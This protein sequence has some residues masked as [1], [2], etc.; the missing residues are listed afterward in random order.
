MSVS[1]SVMWTY[2]LSFA[3]RK[4]STGGRGDEKHDKAGICCTLE[5]VKSSLSFLAL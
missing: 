1:I 5:K 4:L 3:A 2:V